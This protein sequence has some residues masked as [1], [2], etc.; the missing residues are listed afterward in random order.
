MAD[1]LKKIQHSLILRHRRETRFRLYGIGSI[2]LAFAVLISLFSN[3]VWTGM[4]SFWHQKIQLE[5]Y[6]SP[7]VMRLKPT[8]QP[9][10]LKKTRL[11]KVLNNS[12]YH[13]FPEYS[14]RKQK[15]FIRKLR[16]SNADNTVK[17]QLMQNPDWVG[18]TITFWVAASHQLTKL[19]QSVDRGNAEPYQKA[20]W[21]KL[22][23][24]KLLKTNFNTNFFSKGDSRSPEHAG[25][26]GALVG[27]FFTLLV[28]FIVSFP[29][30]IAAAIY[31]EEFAVKNRFTELI[32]VNINNLAAVPSIIFGLLGLSVFINFFQLPRSSPLVG[33][34]VLSLMT[35]PVIIIASRAALK[36]IPSSIQE[37]A[38]GVGA[39]KMQAVF[40]HSFPLAIPG[41]LTG[42][43]IG[44]A[45]ALGE[46]APLLMIGMVAFVVDI[47]QS[48][49]SAATVLP[50]QVYLWA[51]S[52]EVAFVEKT[53]AAIM[54]LLFFLV[55][56]NF[57]AILIRNKLERRW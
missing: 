3:I 41:M 56:M 29:I 46:T 28:T 37:A 34:L 57:A 54:V 15:S 25:I 53:S 45:R 17:K 55:L 2:A 49:T 19:Q 18:Q 31:L 52:P 4:G 36:S 42:S 50:V 11:S 1:Q 39:S 27:T 35:L 51:D 21:Q 48:F 9:E 33:G 8:W 24:Q 43:I 44:M 5:L 22:Q 32:E 20:I 13:I 38:L 6:F 30:G 40:H 7:Q 14:E 16:S 12:L 26:W 23:Q 10:E 47:P